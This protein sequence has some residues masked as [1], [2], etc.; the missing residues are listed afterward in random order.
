M[1]ITDRDNALSLRVLFTIQSH[2]RIN[3][4]KSR[5]IEQLYGITGS[6]VR[7]LVRSYLRQGNLIAHC[8]GAVPGYYLAKDWSEF[9]SSYNDLKSRAMSMLE[10]VNHVAKLHGVS[11][12]LFA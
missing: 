8:G 1:V 4:I 6:E 10:T 11:D 9:E 5:E 3:P 7:N 2:S 12:T